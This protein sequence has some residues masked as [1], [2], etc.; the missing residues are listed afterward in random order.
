MDGKEK[1]KVISQVNALVGV[2]LPNWHFQ[3]EWTKKGQ[4][5]LIPYEILEEA[6]FDNGFKN[7]IEQ[8]VLYIDNIQAAKELGLEVEDAVE[9]T[10]Y[11][12]YTDE[13]LKRLINVASVKDFQSALEVMPSEQKKELYDWAVT[14]R[15]REPEKVKLM[16]Q[17]LGLDVDKA[18][19]M[20][21]LSKEE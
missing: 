10:N 14:L 6:M 3:R 20:D 19:Y 11:K 15:M 7:M 13:E 1:I 16:K 17:A 5:T 18:I 9:P 12:K 4:S 21:V 2:S 8:G